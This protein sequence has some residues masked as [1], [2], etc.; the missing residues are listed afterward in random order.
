MGRAE[1]FL[2]PAPLTTPLPMS[3]HPDAPKGTPIHWRYAT[4]VLLAMALFTCCWRL[5]SVPLFDLDEALYVACARQMLL[6]GDMVTPRLNSHPPGRPDEDTVPFFE[7]PVLVYWAIAGAMRLFGQNE[8]AARLPA[9]GATLMTAALICFAGRWW[10]GERAGWLA[11][12]T[13]VTAPLTVVNARQIT[14]DSLLVLWISLS[15]LTWCFLLPALRPAGRTKDPPA[16]WGVLLFWSACALAVL[17]KGAIGLLLPALVIL[18]ASLAVHVRG[19]L[20]PGNVTLRFC[21]RPLRPAFAEMRT[22]GSAAGL[23]CFLVIVTP[24]HLAIWRAGERDAQGRTFVQE[25]LIRQ[26][27]GR[28]RGGDRV[29]NAPLPTYLVYFLVGFFPWSCF[30]P[31]ALL[32]QAHRGSPDTPALKG[33][34]VERHGE[35]MAHFLKVWFWVV[36]IFFSLSAAKL[37]SYIAPAYP[38]AALL[39][40][41]WL[42]RALSSLDVRRSL[43]CG[44]GAS[45][46]VAGLLGVAVLVAPRFVTPAS[47]VPGEVLRLSQTLVL[48]LSVGCCVAWWLVRR[49]HWPH[50]ARAGFAVLTLTLL[51]CYSIAVTAGYDVVRRTVQQPYQQL[52][53]SANPDADRGWPVIYY[54]IVPRRPSMLFYARY[55]AYERKEV[56]LRPLLEPLLAR[57]R[58]ALIITSRHT[59]K[60][61]LE[62]ELSGDPGLR[63]QVERTTGEAHSGWALVR[64]LPVAASQTL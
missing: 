14:T 5:G 45:A 22:L 16:R 43:V 40:G 10:F 19:R 25:Y 39:T 57:Y 18:V 15:L 63:Y 27:L 31:V 48:A 1:S 41:R 20:R 62:P 64:V 55:S 8:G 3:T 11:A 51:L 28:F 60:T 61:L 34:S 17:T 33:V 46:L 29:H 49:R 56:P 54:H 9:A 32:T 37:P 38:A 59:L 7:K 36:L 26:H 2:V 42:D 13:F 47:P 24:W 6:R 44:T 58:G 53:A 21:W 52:A 4:I 30:A 35:D 23:L 12:L 50:A